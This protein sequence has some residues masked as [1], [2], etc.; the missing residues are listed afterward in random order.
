MVEAGAA[1]DVPNRPKASTGTV[2]ILIEARRVHLIVTGPTEVSKTNM[3]SLPSPGLTVASK[4]LCL[5][6]SRS[7]ITCKRCKDILPICVH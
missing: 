3:P 7:T 2:K 5:K 6:H 4:S 1:V